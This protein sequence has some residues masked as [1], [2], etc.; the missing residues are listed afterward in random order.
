MERTRLTVSILVAGL[1]LAYFATW[2]PAALAAP[3]PNDDFANRQAIG[4]TLP[5]EV[6]GSNVDATEEAG[7]SLEAPSV[8]GHSV[9]FKWE[10][11]AGGWTTIGSCHDAIHPVVAIFEGTALDSLYKVAKSG[12]VS[13]P[14]E[15]PHCSTTESEFTFMAKAG[16]TYVIAV[17]GNTNPSIRPPLTEGEFTLRI[18]STPPPPNDDFQ[19]ATPLERVFSEFDP[20]DL[21]RA[22]AFGYNWGATKE[23]GEPNHGGDPGGASVWYSWT[24]PLSGPA[25]IY[26]CCTFTD[27]ELGFYTGDAVNA[28]TPVLETGLSTFLVTAG[29]TYHLAVDGRHDY[30]EEGGPWM[31]SFPLWIAMALPPAPAADSTAQILPPAPEASLPRTTIVKHKVMPHARG[32]AFRF[33]SSEQGGSFLCRL[34]GHPS[35]PCRSP[36]TY[37][38]L[39][40]GRHTFE[41]VALDPA[42]ARDPTPAIAK[43]QLPG[44][45]SGLGGHAGR[46][47]AS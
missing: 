18:E 32:A 30:G 35:S 44:N 2:I 46:R 14:S 26:L 27:Q 22:P 40:P 15:G 28:L 37:S 21:Y 31:G 47:G 12:V 4:S 25:E 24:A 16:T 10:A 7:E 9:W 11:P 36:K 6:A 3:P 8:A 43:F 38:R 17:D 1:L 23:S 33:R 5:V 20:P 34:D 41:V 13:S 19:N 42:G 29:Q 39:R 45:R